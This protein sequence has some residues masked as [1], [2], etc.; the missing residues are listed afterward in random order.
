MERL[1]QNDWFD[2]FESWRREVLRGML[3]VAAIIAPIMV[4]ISLS[5]RATQH[6]WPKIALFIAAGLAFPALRLLPRLSVAARAS[7]AILLAF[8]TGVL[9]LAT[10]GFSSGPGVVLVGTS[11]F[12]VIFLGRAQGLFFIALS[13]TA[14]F[15]VGAL[16][17]R[18]TLPLAGLALDLDP[19]RM[20]N[21]MRIG[22]SFAFLSILMTTAIDFVI[23]HVE[24]SSRATSRALGRLRLAHEH[25]GQLHR[26]LDATKEEERRSLSRE[27][28]DELAQ[29]LTALKLRLQLGARA[30]GARPGAS[31]GPAD[32]EP[33]AL[34]DDLISRVRKISVDLRP[35]LLDE[36][37]FVS[38]LRVYLEGQAALSGLEITL[39]AE[40]PLPDQD[41]RLPADFEITCFRVV[42][43]SVTNAL[44][45]AAARRI[46]IRIVRLGDRVSLSIRDDGRG[47]A[48]SILD[49]AAAR[50]HLGIVGMRERVR[51]RDGR[52]ELTSRPGAGTAIAVELTAQPIRR[53][54][55]PE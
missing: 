30:C 3:T 5:S 27:L 42:Q 15:V 32:L 1:E 18:G 40:E 26:R 50:G 51:A 41:R 21:W 55:E 33:V 14:F 7:T 53:P 11:V 36:V 34:V 48:P 47:F 35:P 6:S 29:T 43:E 16:A 39:E 23:R 19:H 4:V 2:G 38:A 54:S 20:R 25:L 12:A 44:R 9:A 13:V 46:E 37:G 8:S 52:F 28:H 49:A 24:A 17:A 31:G 10:F 22:I 45:H